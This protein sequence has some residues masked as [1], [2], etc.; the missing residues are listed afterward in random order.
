MNRSMDR[1]I[2]IDGPFYESIDGSI[3]VFKVKTMLRVDVASCFIVHEDEDEND[4][5]HDHKDEDIIC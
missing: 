5:L 2:S 4:R 3:N 1:S